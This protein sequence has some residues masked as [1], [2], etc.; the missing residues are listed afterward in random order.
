MLASWNLR[1]SMAGSPTRLLHS[2]V[3]GLEEQV[4]NMKDAVVV[5]SALFLLVTGQ[6]KLD[7]AG[8]SVRM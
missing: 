6:E 7:A 2:L 3:R 8:G 5:T 1:P 4:G